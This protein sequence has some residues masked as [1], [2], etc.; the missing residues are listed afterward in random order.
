MKRAKRKD[1]TIKVLIG[2]PCCGKTT[3]RNENMDEN[4]VFI[5]M[6][7]F[8]LELCNTPEDYSKCY[9]E[10]DIKA[11][12]RLFNGRFDDAIK[13]RK[14]IIVD[15][16]NMTSKTRRK[17][18]ARVPEEYT[19]IAVLFEWDY[20]VLVER[21]EQRKIEE[22]KYLKNLNM[23]ID[24]FQPINYDEGFDKTITIKGY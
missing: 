15:R 9:R 2:P 6:D 1:L 8:M 19:K 21:N 4:D 23:F 22:N 16:T 11:V 18:L 3:W 13:E 24:N 17:L 12:K 10:Q 14:N 5:S 20:D 7:D